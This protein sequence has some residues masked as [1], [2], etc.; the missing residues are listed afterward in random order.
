MM[1]LKDPGDFGWDAPVNSAGKLKIRTIP[2]GLSPPAQRLRG[3]SYPG[4]SQEKT[5][6][7]LGIDEYCWTM[8]QGSTFIAN[9]GFDAESRW[10][11]RNDAGRRNR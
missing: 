6:N 5:H 10:D 3:T 1:L 8:S 9:Q 7:P 11:S 4:W 2:T